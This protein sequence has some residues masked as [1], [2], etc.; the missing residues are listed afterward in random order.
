M[1]PTITHPGTGKYERLLERCRGLAPI[2]TAVAYPCE[3]TALAGAMDA[4][5]QGLIE[6]ILVGPAATIAEIAGRKASTS[7]ARR[8][9]T[10]PTATP[11][12]PKRWNWS[13]RAGPNWS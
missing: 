6:P 12:R 13:A 1:N 7:V 9:W 2:P 5:T 10:R 8:L 4:A 11:R 3:E